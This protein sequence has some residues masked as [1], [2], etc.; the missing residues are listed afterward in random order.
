M[1]IDF[2]L[3]VDS[4]IP[5]YDIN[6]GTF[7]D[8][9]S[10]DVTAIQR[11]DSVF[12]DDFET[13]TASLW[14]TTAESSSLGFHDD[15]WATSIGG[16]F[17]PLHSS[18]VGQW[19]GYVPSTPSRPVSS[20]QSSTNFNVNYENTKCMS[21]GHISQ[22]R[23]IK[24]QSLQ[25]PKLI[26]TIDY[27]GVISQCPTGIE[28]YPTAPID[29]EFKNEHK[30]FVTQWG[31]DTRESKGT[32]DVRYRQAKVGMV[33]YSMC[34]D[35]PAVVTSFE[36]CSPWCVTSSGGEVLVSDLRNTSRTLRKYR[37]D[38]ALNESWTEHIVNTPRGVATHGDRVIVTDTH[39][40]NVYVVDQNKDG[41]AQ[42]I[43]S[44]GAV[45]K[46]GRFRSESNL[47]ATAVS[48]SDTQFINPL[49]AACNS[50]GLILVSDAG[51]NAIKFYDQ[52]GECVGRITEARPG[53]PLDTPMGLCVDSID[54]VYVCDYGND[55]VL[56]FNR[57]GHLLAEVL[58]PTKGDVHRPRGVD[59][60]AGFLAVTCHSRLCEPQVKVFELAQ[61]LARQPEPPCECQWLRLCAAQD[62]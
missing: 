53:D 11:G 43:N 6:I 59:V 62:E 23:E 50:V 46:L 55:R 19:E 22:V 41:F 34:C 54:N 15:H 30:L 33:L 25:D 21:F 26:F 48:Y 13:T 39:H 1:H 20:S 40:R 12:K 51:D 2:C 45:A 57:N 27:T 56:K 17:E 37:A 28:T 29:V 36:D 5:S 61:Q 14:D 8:Q 10:L 4:F 18:S 44:I 52:G 58:S 35:Q 24:P 32:A 3:C 47:S 16:D 7:G 38:G 49:F 42:R 31:V 9:V 60:Y